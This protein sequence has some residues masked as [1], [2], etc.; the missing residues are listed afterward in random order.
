MRRFINATVIV[1]LLA[2]CSNTEVLS[3]SP[4]PQKFAATLL[5]GL[6]QSMPVRISE[7]HYDN[8]GNDNTEWIEISGPAN[9]NLQGYKIELY[10]G[11]TGLSYGTR[12]LGGTIPL[13]CNGRGVV[14]HMLPLN[15]LQD[16]PDGMALVSPSNTVI[17]FLS[18]EGSFTAVNGPAAGM[19][20]AD[21]GVFEPGNGSA[22][23][24]TSVW[25]NGASTIWSGPSQNTFGS[26]NDQNDPPPAASVELNPPSATIIKGATQQYSAVAYNSS[27]QPIVN[28]MFSWSS[29]NPAVATVSATG[30]A[31]GV[32]PGDAMIIA[33]AENGTADT[34]QVHVVPPPVASVEVTPA[35]ASIVVYGTQQF[36]AV[37]FDASH[38]PVPTA[39]ISWSSSS[40]VATVS[41]SGLATGVSPGDVVITASSEGK[42]ATAQVHVDP[43]PVVSVEV[44]PASATIVKGATQQYAAVAFDAFHQPVASATISW[45]TSN[46]SV[47]TVNASGLA[48]GLAPGDAMIIASSEGKTGTAQLHVVPPPVASVEVTPSSASILVGATQQFTGVAFDASH[49]PNPYAT[50]SWSSSN[51]SIATVNASGLA[52]GV[53]PGDVTITA[54]AEGKTATA[55]LHVESPNH[56][57]SA[58]VNGPFNGLEAS[59]VSMSGAASTDPDAGEVLTYAWNF[60]DGHTG[61]GANVSHTYPQDG[62]YNVQLTVTDSY[63]LTSSATAKATIG[64]VA[65]YIGAFAGAMLLP[66]ETYS[67]NGSFTDPGADTWNATVD[68]GDGSGASAVA[69]SGKT[70]SLSHVYASAGTYTVTVRISDDDVTSSR[71]ET[72]TVS[73][74]G[75]GVTDALALLAQLV[76]DGKIEQSYA[77]PIREALEGVLAKLAD[78]KMDLVVSQLDASLKH[79]DAAVIVAKISAAD[80]DPLRAQIIRVMQSLGL[81]GFAAESKGKRRN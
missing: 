23:P 66:G 64:N 27:Q 60:G 56:P 37:A 44:T 70:F 20:S 57:P 78:G 25:R 29:T 54:S 81:G 80:A 3:P 74:V 59:P 31:T 68:Y 18:Y 21:I 51:A 72:V 17:E 49:Q 58:A 2:A 39:T 26:C 50:I 19:T 12:F 42:S 48:T 1:A 71:T 62:V 28:A 55:Q 75:K 7:F 4:V 61:T 16:G 41:G 9:T 15:L 35:S 65:P 32:A 45:G 47:A 33:S 6:N 63:G 8:V 13:I 14:L 53:A 73:T 43:P 24:V 67:S 10:D 79:L 38:Q 11:A 5:L 69:L 22:N 40:S 52:T 46:P 34:A 77:N 30:L 36:S 76:A